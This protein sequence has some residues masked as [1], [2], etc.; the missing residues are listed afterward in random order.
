MP[1]LVAKWAT[2][3]HGPLPSQWPIHLLNLAQAI[4]MLVCLPSFALCYAATA[5]MSSHLR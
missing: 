5:T 1:A 4:R 2:Y 3:P